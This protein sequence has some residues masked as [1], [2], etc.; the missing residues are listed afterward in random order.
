[1]FKRWFIQRHRVNEVDLWEWFLKHLP[2]TDKSSDY[3]GNGRSG[4]T[5]TKDSN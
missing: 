3:V 4:E 5:T 1:M 2:N